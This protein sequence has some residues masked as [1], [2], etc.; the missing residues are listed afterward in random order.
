MK[1]VRNIVFILI[2]F[3]LSGCIRDNLD[4]CPPRVNTYLTFSY[5]G[6]TNDPS[7]F[8]RMIHHITLL[9][10]DSDGQ[11]VLTRLIPKSDL[12]AFQ[13][14]RLFLEPG[15]YRAICWGNADEYTEISDAGSFTTGRLQHPNLLLGQNIPTN[16]H[17]YYGSF[18]FSVDEGRI[19]EGDIPMRGAHIN[20]EVYL[21]GL[22]AGDNGYSVRAHNLMPQYDLRMDDTQPFATTYYPTMGYNAERALDECRF[23][24]LRF[25][26]DNPVVIEILRPTGDPLIVNLKEYMAGNSLTVNEK[27]EA[28]VPILFEFSDLGIEIK[29]PEWLSHN[30]TPGT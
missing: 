5:L 22:A 20:I 4:H 9:V 23:Q 7:M 13:G 29:I 28:T 18:D 26:D 27:N 1:K 25:A 11:Q 19:A 21:R 24:V 6:D 16:S 10:F 15:D 8:R 2:A 30:V 14:T 17:L 12:E 3:S